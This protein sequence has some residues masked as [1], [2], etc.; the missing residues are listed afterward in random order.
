MS[1]LPTEKPA[2]GGLLRIRHRSPGSGLRCFLTQIAGSLRRTFEKFPFLGDGDRLAGLRQKSEVA[3][4]MTS[5][6][7]YLNRRTASINAS[8]TKKSPNPSLVLT[9]PSST[10]QSFLAHVLSNQDVSVGI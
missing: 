1:F 2:N 5:Y 4:A 3:P 10:A 6:W 9:L 7:D 8:K